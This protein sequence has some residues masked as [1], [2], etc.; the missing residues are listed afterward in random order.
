MGLCASQDKDTKH[1]AG[2]SL[3]KI[4][5]LVRNDKITASHKCKIFIGMF[6][7]NANTSQL[8]FPQDV[9]YKSHFNPV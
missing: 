7:L 1:K 9:S 5:H 4:L 2:N 8:Y 3:M 6:S